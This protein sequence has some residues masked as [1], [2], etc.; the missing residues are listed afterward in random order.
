MATKKNE[1]G[2]TAEQLSELHDLAKA[3]A[4]GEKAGKL[5]K[6]F[7][8]FRDDHVNELLDGIEVDGLRL[9]VKITKTLQVEEL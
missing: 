9:T 7:E 1:Y 2:L 3:Q 6:R 5:R 4:E 8:A